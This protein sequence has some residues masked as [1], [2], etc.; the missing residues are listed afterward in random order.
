MKV[1]SEGEGI[2]TCSNTRLTK[3]EEEEEEEEEE[4]NGTVWLY[5]KRLG[6][7]VTLDSLASL[8]RRWAGHYDAI[9]MQGKTE[10]DYHRNEDKWDM[11]E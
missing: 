9:E 8:G 3:E 5:P 6:I 11:Q 10:M 7:C 1:F 2:K 4:V